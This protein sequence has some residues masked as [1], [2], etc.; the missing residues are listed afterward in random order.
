MDH[1]FNYAILRASPDARRGECVNIGVIVFLPDRIDVRVSETRKTVVLTGKSWDS[2]VQDYAELLIASD[3]PDFDDVERVG[4]LRSIQ[5]E[6][7]MSDLGW[8]EARGTRQ[9]EKSINDILKALVVR[10][11][12]PR[13]S[14]AAKI[15][16]EISNHFRSAKIMAGADDDLASGKV[17]RNL[18]IDRDEGLSA[19]F[20]LQNGVLNVATTLDF[21]SSQPRKGQAALKAITL[22][23]ARRVFDGSKVKRLAVYAVAPVRQDEVRE[24][25]S[26]LRDYSDELFNWSIA[27]E[28]QK[29]ERVFFDAYNARV[30]SK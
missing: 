5:N 16:S 11:K 21:R 2:Y 4:L 22:D 10:P 18:V 13:G 15:N 17:I 7:T 23:K 26:L 9:Y 1:T 27:A 12:V 25:I 6:I 28:R 14:A 29:F 8:F 19:D 3:N 24:H 20:A 30:D